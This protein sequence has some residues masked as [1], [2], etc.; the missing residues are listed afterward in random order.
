M[1]NI[2]IVVDEFEDDYSQYTPWLSFT[3]L[4][5]SDFAPSCGLTPRESSTAEPGKGKVRFTDTFATAP[6]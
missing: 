2:D 4:P 3:L 6:V 1:R 5:W